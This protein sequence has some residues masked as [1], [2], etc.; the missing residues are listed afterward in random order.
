MRKIIRTSL[1]LGLAVVAAPI[2]ARAGG[3]LFID[4]ATGLPIRYSGTVPVYTDLGSLGMLTNQQADAKVAF[5]WQQWTDV[6]TSSFEARIAGDFASAGLPDVTAANAS[7]VIGTFNGGGVYVVYDTDG[8]VLSD[9]FGAPPSV[10]GIASPEFG[11]D[12][13]PEITEG[14][15]VLNGLAIDPADADGSA[16]AGVMTHEFGHSI[17]LGHSQVNGPALFFGDPAGPSGCPD[18]PFDGAPARDDVETMYPFIDVA[19][20]T[21]TGIAQST[22]DVTDDVVSLSN[23]YPVATWPASAG[24]IAGTITAS[25]GRTQVGGV[26]VVARNVADPFRDAVSVMTGDVTRAQTGT[27][28]RYVL[29]GLTPGASYV[30]SVEGIVAG[31][32]STPPAVFFPGPEEFFNGAAESGNADT[33]AACDATPVAAVAG[34]TVVADIALNAVPGAPLLNVI[35]RDLAPSGITKDGATI[36]GYGTVLEA[37]AF[38]FTE[39]AGVEILG[40][41][42]STAAIAPNGTA[43]VSNTLQ[44]DGFQ[45]AS[46]WAG[47]MDW[48][49]L[50]GLDGSCDGALPITKT[51]AF[52]VSNGG[53]RVVGLGFLGEHCYL[54]RAFQWDAATGAT[55]QLETPDSA[56]QSRANGISGDGSIVWGFTVGET[57]FRDGAI[58][59]NGRLTVLGTAEDLVGEALG[60]SANG[61]VVVGSGLGIDG[62]AWR[63]SRRTGLESIGKL[64]D[65]FYASGFATNGTG[66]VITGQSSSFFDL[67]GF[68]WTRSLGMMRIEEFLRSQGTSL[69]PTAILYAPNTM[70]NSGRRIAGVGASVNGSFA[71]YVDIEQVRVCHASTDGPRTVVVPFPDGL[72]RH[73]AHG[74]TLGDCPA[75]RR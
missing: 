24:S 54:A 22:V 27:E 67:A 36:V 61:K 32:F 58:W 21:G 73:L 69:D 75:V 65:T 11:V 74:D 60:A 53:R 30:V 55:T 17:N 39:S 23:L 16:F 41:V 13:T 59:T 52:G 12:G 47:G 19:P 49:Q 62:F 3:P 7:S 28:G 57:G 5:A 35:G 72:D 4:P 42:G 45:V 48:Q 51:V 63:W 10:L 44:P 34:T 56:L 2:A 15:V 20:S 38:R 37:P 66:S 50:P 71:W 33:D 64:P 26:N 6:P 8:T 46:L 14:W 25:G 9:F 43:I 29:N 68:I 18:L 70:S 1:L 31:G 40:G